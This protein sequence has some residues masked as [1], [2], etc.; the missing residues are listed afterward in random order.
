MASVSSSWALHDDRWLSVYSVIWLAP[1]TLLVVGG[2]VVASVAAPRGLMWALG[3][4]VL[5][6][7]ALWRVVH[8][9][10][11]AVRWSGALR[12]AVVIALLGW[13][14]VGLFMLLSTAGALLSVVALLSAPPLVRWVVRLSRQAQDRRT[15]RWVGGRSA[16]GL[17]VAW[18]IRSG[19]DT[20]DSIPDQ[21]VD[22]GW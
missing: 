1:V 17:R 7:L 10:D 13:A 2:G 11:D 21:R 5:S 9:P 19:D 20:A 18:W 15:L 6:G 16:E 22:G 14:V 8:D 12:A 3:L 4:F